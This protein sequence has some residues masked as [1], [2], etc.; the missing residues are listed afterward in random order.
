MAI[1]VVEVAQGTNGSTG[2]G[3]AVSIAATPQPGDIVYVTLGA[4]ANNRAIT[5]MTGLGATW[6][7][8][9]TVNTTSATTSQT[10]W[11]G[12]GA[13]T[14]GTIA[15]T[16]NS[17]ANGSVRAFLVRGMTTPPHVTANTFTSGTVAL[18][19]PVNAAGVGTFVLA[20]GFAASKTT[21]N[22]QEATQPATGWV[23]QTGP[24]G[25][26]AYHHTGYLIPTGLGPAQCTIA[27]GSSASRQITQ[28]VFGVAAPSGFTGW[29]VP[30]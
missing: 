6:S 9:V 21:G 16:V 25:A 27:A 12:I 30:V 3:P 1:T 4:A 5:G 14:S 11:Q 15:I 7:E 19:G 20:L 23:I 13:T 18:P 28:V 26:T 24:A 2:L 10:V 8:V 17:S 22:L 29:G